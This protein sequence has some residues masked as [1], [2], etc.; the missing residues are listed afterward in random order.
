MVT[1]SVNR[2]YGATP[3]PWDASPSPFSFFGTKKI[4][5]DQMNMSH[6]LK[7]T[8]EQILYILISSERYDYP[9][10]LL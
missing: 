4:A 5:T 7:E 9:A 8:A 1:L 2:L 6:F 3:G 10:A